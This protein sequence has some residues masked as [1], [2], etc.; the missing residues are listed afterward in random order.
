MNKH[1]TYY[2]NCEEAPQQIYRHKYY[3]NGAIPS[4]GKPD[5]KGKPADWS[6]IRLDCPKNSIALYAAHKSDFSQYDKLGFTATCT[7]GYDVYIDKKKYGTYASNAKCSITWSKYNPN[8]PAGYTQVEYLQSSG[9]QYLDLGIKGNGTTKA[10]IKYRYNTATSASGSGRVF[11]SRTSSTNNAFAVGTSSGVVASTGNKAFWCYDAQDFYVINDVT[12]PIDEWQTIVFSA[13]EHTLNGVSYGDDYTVSTFETPQNLKLFGFDNNG[14]V[15]VG[16]VD[17][18]YCKLWDNGTLVRNLIPC[19]NSSNVLGMYDTVNDVFYENEGSGTF[20]G[21]NE[22]YPSTTGNIITTPSLLKA[23]KIWI[24]PATEGA[25]I[26]AFK[27]QRVASS[28]REAQGLLWAHFNTNNVI[29]L[30]SGFADYN[31]YY[32]PILLSITSK[33]NVLNVSKL[34]RFG[35]GADLS[36]YADNV[37]YL[38]VFDLNNNSSTAEA[39]LNLLTTA[40]LEEVTIKNGTIT[41][42]NTMAMNATKLKKINTKNVTFSGNKYQSFKNCQSLE[43]LPELSW[44]SVDNA[45]DF[46][47]NAK[48]L[49]NTVLDTRGSTALKKI[50]CYGTSTYFMTGFKG[51]RV[52]SSAPF[53]HGTSPQINISYTGMDRQAL[54][55][56]FNDLPTV[57][58]GQIIN[59]TGCTGSENL[60]PEDV[61]IATNKGWT[62]TGGPV[63]ITYYAYT[64]EN[65]TS[66]YTKD[67]PIATE[68]FAFDTNFT[69]SGTT[70]TD[71]G[72]ARGGSGT[73]ILSTFK[74]NFNSVNSWE[75]QITFK[76]D[77]SSGGAYGNSILSSSTAQPKV[78]YLLI[79]NDGF[80]VCLSSN[81]SSYDIVDASP[82]TYSFTTGETYNAR[83]GFTGTEYYL[84]VKQKDEQ[85]P[86]THYWS[87]ASTTKVYSNTTDYLELMNYYGQEN[88]MYFTGPMNLLETKL[89]LGNTTYNVGSLT[90]PSTLY[91]SSLQEL[92]PQPQFETNLINY[93]NYNCTIADNK[94]TGGYGA[95]LE[96]N[97]IDNLNTYSTWSFHSKF[98]DGGGGGGTYG[99]CLLGTGSGYGISLGTLSDH[100]L[101]CSMSSTN[102]NWDI[103]GNNT[104]LNKTLT[105]SNTYYIEFGYEG[106]QYYC[107]C[108][109]T[110]ITNATQPIWTLT[111]NL[112]VNTAMLWLLNFYYSIPTQYFTGPIDL[113]ET[114]FK[115]DNLTVGF[116]IKGITINN[117]Y[118]ARTPANDKQGV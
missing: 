4:T 90:A 56:L 97:N 101:F 6:D 78:P 1:H 92:E 2:L 16:Y 116:T 35:Q 115:L 75:F 50:G 39:F 100:K 58:N 62:V 99:Q 105:S 13:T 38:P 91:N 48:G 89:V 28:G 34:P 32:E 98:T 95:R 17:V 71:E 25:D 94:A 82:R 70:V 88:T 46:L 51:L 80:R 77:G 8:L 12:F 112:K 33:K 27:M 60:L 26:T 106:T 36:S 19:K 18:E 103:A 76:H 20:T 64:D 55:T 14:T 87:L 63:F 86:A 81:G 3:M 45:T 42:Q 110:P 65:N 93:D 10:E 53:N 37:E 69:N 114:Y 30:Q 102:S 31:T 117:D 73:K 47:T 52:S 67:N 21:G 11:G 85:Y 9:T 57:T 96:L 59:I 41:S 5:W 7:G 111:S 118:Y 109:D 54:V 44:T 49:K 74:P 68:A 83:F 22:I 66:V 113:S 108:E 104:Y 72:W 79:F 43:E 84:D 24:E 15:G 40:N 29:N 61:E 23:H 107:K